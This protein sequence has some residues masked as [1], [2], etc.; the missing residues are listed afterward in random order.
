MDHGIDVSGFNTVT[1]WQAVA[2]DGI[3][4]A[5]VKLTQGNYFQSGAAGGQIAGAR[6]A[7]IAV[8]GYHFGDLNIGVAANVNEFV[9]VGQ[10]VGVFG[11]GSFVPMLDIEDDPADG[12]RWSAATANAFI[13]DWIAGVRAAT[14]VADVAVYANLGFWRS[15]L[16]PN[17][18]ADDHVYLW[19]ADYDGDPGDTGGWT[20]PRLALHQHTD[21]GNVPGV[22]GPVDKNVTVG[23]FGVANLIL[24]GSVNGG[25]TGNETDDDMAGFWFIG[26]LSDAS[27]VGLLY[28]NGDFVGVAGS[29]YVDVIRANGI[30]KLDVPDEVWDDMAARHGNYAVQLVAHLAQAFPNGLTLDPTALAQALREAFG[31]DVQWSGNAE[32]QLKVGNAPASTPPAG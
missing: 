8:G 30:P 14:G 27:S 11:P 6:A 24:G 16:V 28:P 20:H 7:G 22:A 25:A 31:A 12:I 10:A 18:W 29:N 32:L 15:L 4:Y 5:S 19:L 13:P 17:Y 3:R 2:G 1:D 23:A 9:T 26:K 21:A